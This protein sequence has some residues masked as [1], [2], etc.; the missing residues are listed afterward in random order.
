[1]TDL[2][3]LEL[4]ASE[5]RSRL[6]E[7]G[8][9]ADLDAEQREELDALGKEYG[10]C[11]R[12]QRALKVAGDSPIVT[13]TSEGTEYR[14][15]IARSNVGV[16]FDDLLGQ[17]AT[18]GVEAELQD[19]LGIKGNQIPLDMLRGNWEE[20]A[21]TPGATNVGTDQQPVI[22]YVFPMGAAAFLGV[23]QPTVPTGDAVFPVLTGTL[24]VHSPAE[25][26]AAAETIGAF[27]SDVLTPQRLQASVFLFR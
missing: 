12:R 13:Q 11:E 19:F 14:A 8:M 23:A 26:A 20:R 27:S 25:N 18:T 21:V 4:R 5:I 6:A 7:L 9:L 3:T 15:M 2:Q 22:P 17:R 10:D 1:M 16:I 24:D